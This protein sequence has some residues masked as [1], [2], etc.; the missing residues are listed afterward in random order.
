MHRPR[1]YKFVHEHPLHSKFARL[2]RNSSPMA[3]CSLRSPS[4]I[5]L[6][7]SLLSSGLAHR[8]SF[9]GAWFDVV[10][11]VLHEMQREWP[12]H[13]RRTFPTDVVETPSAFEVTT[14]APGFSPE[15][16]DVQLHQDILTITGKQQSSSEHKD[17]AGRVLQ[18]ERMSS[19]FTRSF[20]L[21]DGVKANDIRAQLSQGIL[22]IVV[23]KVEPLPAAEPRKIAVQGGVVGNVAGSAED[24]SASAGAVSNDA[25]TQ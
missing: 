10:P 13:A 6:L 17:D 19:S 4:A 20:K 2:P 25:A 11:A 3:L 18:R 23:P 8:S 1:V 9:H 22:K 21:P 14:D 16:I 5:R 15:D 24:G 7:D 12:S